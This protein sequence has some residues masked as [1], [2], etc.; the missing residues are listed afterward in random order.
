MF[1]VNDT[2]EDEREEIKIERDTALVNKSANKLLQII[3]TP[4][5]EN[6]DFRSP[7]QYKHIQE[8][9]NNSILP[10]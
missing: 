6:D 9:H 2:T 4:T 1:I 5:I 8:A 10:S 7:V 3:K